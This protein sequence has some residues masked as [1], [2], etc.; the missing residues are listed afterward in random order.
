[1]GCNVHQSFESYLCYQQY[2]AANARVLLNLPKTL[3]PVHYLLPPQFAD[4][5]IVILDAPTLL[6]T[7]IQSRL[8]TFAE[9]SPKSVPE[10]KSMPQSSLADFS[11]LLKGV[12][13][14]R[15][16]RSRGY[17]PPAQNSPR[18]MFQTLTW[19][20]GSLSGWSGIGITLE[21]SRLGTSMSP[22]EIL[23]TGPGLTR[24]TRR[25]MGAARKI[26]IRSNL[27]NAAKKKDR[28]GRE[29]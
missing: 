20:N 28:L 19:T 15:G 17:L 18:L 14:A 27:S 24:G 23:A 10:S 3:F 12:V 13:A 8:N 9:K 26:R 22:T 21:P 7:I 29:E 1:M 5:H 6:D 11:K 2:T 16:T 25:R 4:L